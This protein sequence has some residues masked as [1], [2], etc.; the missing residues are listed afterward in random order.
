MV[1]CFVLSAFLHV[2]CSVFV[3]VWLSR[4]CNVTQHD[5]GRRGR[6]Y[7]QRALRAL[8]RTLRRPANVVL[9]SV[10]RVHGNADDTSRSPFRKAV[11]P[12]WTYSETE[13]ARRPSSS[14]LSPAKVGNRDERDA[15]A[16]DDQL[17]KQ[18]AFENKGED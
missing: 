8:H 11:C 6:R 13:S 4:S 9:P 5:E 16:L 1:P 2:F 10:P 18:R 12:S 14:R 3:H 15:L 7:S 17:F